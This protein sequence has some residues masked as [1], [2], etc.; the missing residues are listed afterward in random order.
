MDLFTIAVAF[1]GKISRL[2]AGKLHEAYCGYYDLYLPRLLNLTEHL[3]SG[4][5]H[6]A[7]DLCVLDFKPG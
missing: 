7:A 5:L 6:A 4:H 2:E 1:D 3:R